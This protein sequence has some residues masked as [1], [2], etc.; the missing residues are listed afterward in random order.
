MAPDLLGI[1]LSLSPISQSNSRDSD[2]PAFVIAAVIN[3]PYH[4]SKMPVMKQAVDM[5]GFSPN[6]QLRATVT[7]LVS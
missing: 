7:L 1:L 2:V 3:L 4:D 6:P 5:S